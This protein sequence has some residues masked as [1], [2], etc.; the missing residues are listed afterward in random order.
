MTNHSPNYYNAMYLIQLL[1]EQ[2]RHYKISR[3]CGWPRHGQFK[4][5]CI[6]LEDDESDG[7]LYRPAGRPANPKR[8]F[9]SSTKDVFSVERLAQIPF[10]STYLSI[11]YL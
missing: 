3:T 10:Q 8:A 6:Q 11:L 7:C 9:E 1:R 4:I 5:P 2:S